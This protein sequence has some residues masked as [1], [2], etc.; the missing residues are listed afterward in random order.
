MVTGGCLCQLPDAEARAVGAWSG[1]SCCHAPVCR[2]T[3]PRCAGH[4]LCPAGG[5]LCC[6]E[7]YIVIS[8]M[9]VAEQWHCS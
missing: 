9:G 3:V 8:L 4:K 2:R 1:Y 5:T 7:L 6:V